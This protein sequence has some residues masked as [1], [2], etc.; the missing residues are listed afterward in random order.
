MNIDHAVGRR[1]MCQRLNVGIV[2]N[3][4][5][6]LIYDNIEVYL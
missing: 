2:N 4:I 1:P 6:E 3:L 5:N